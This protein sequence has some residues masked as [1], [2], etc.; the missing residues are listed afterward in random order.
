MAL[1]RAAL[2]GALLTGLAAGGA[3]A[4]AAAEV[5]TG[6][7]QSGVSYVYWGTPRYNSHQQNGMQGRSISTSGWGG[8]W[9]AFTLGA[10]NGSASSATQIARVDLTS[11]VG[12]GV[13][14]T[15]TT[16]SGSSA[17]PRGNF[18]L[19]THLDTFCVTGVDCPGTQQVSFN[20]GLRWDL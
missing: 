16:P 11:V 5:N 9:E 4:A 2:C 18:W 7:T 14:R 10:R 3:G 17:I 20:I 15:F 13:W 19:T 12:A 1:V 6:G 8:S